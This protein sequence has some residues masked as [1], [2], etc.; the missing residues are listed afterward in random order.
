MTASCGHLPSAGLRIQCLENGRGG[1]KSISRATRHHLGRKMSRKIS[2]SKSGPVKY[3]GPHCSEKQH[4]EIALRLFGSEQT[5]AKLPPQNKG[6]SG[7]GNG[8]GHNWSGFS[9]RIN[10][11][12]EGSP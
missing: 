4:N 11:I 5:H 8:D 3:A 2:P 7:E 9:T 12:N 6:R 10:R 1:L